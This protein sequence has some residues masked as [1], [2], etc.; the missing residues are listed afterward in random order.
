[1]KTHFI[2]LAYLTLGLVSFQANATLVSTTFS[3]SVTL[4]NGGA[5]PF[6]LVNGDSISGSA[7]FDDSLVTGN[8]PDENILINGLTD[9]DFEIT[10]GSF[11]FSQS[12]VT[13]PAFTSF[14]FNNGNFDGIEFF[15]EPINIGLFSNLLIEDFDGGRSLFVEDVTTGN[16]VYLE[17]N[18]DFANATTP[19]PV[20]PVNPPTAVPLPST[21]IML[22]IG[23]GA[24][25][26]TRL[27][28][29]Q[30]D[31]KCALVKV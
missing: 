14:Y 20:N 24:L 17:A 26:S 19:T 11:S 5:N 25:A 30:P 22:L 6:G 9:W 31:A 29:P 13:D 10:L 28:K 3:G 1:M 23:F 4:D 2:I 21:L 8:S 18:W 16:P 12:D 7:T 27:L 15:I